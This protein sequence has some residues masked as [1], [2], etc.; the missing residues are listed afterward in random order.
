LARREV[1]MAIMEVSVV[2]LGTQSPSVGEYVTRAVKVLKEAGAKY[3]V[4]PMSTIMEGELDDLFHLAK[5]MH[6]A[7][8]GG[9][10]KRVV[11]TLKIDHRRDQKLTMNEKVEKVKRGL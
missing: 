5:M 8:F 3:T 10:A 7:T 6:L 2:P 9:E 4:T 1:K 11:T